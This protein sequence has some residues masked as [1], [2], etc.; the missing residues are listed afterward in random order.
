MLH[1]RTLRHSLTVFILASALACASSSIPATPPAAIARPMALAAAPDRYFTSGDARLRY[2]DIGQGDAVILIHGLSR[3]LDD[4]NG[5]GDSLALDHRVIALDVRGFGKSTRFTDRA[6]LGRQMAEDVVRLMDNL[7]IRR[8]HLAGHSMGAAIAAKIAT[9]YP[10]RVSSV[11]LLAGPFYEDTL[12]FGNDQRG[13]ATEIEQRRSM[14]TLIRWLFPTA[15]DSIVVALN[16]DAMSHNDPATI[17]AAM[18]SMDALLVLPRSAGAI[19]A[20]TV[21]IVGGGDPL[22]P[23]SRWLASWWP[24]ARLVEIPEADH[25]TVL[26]HPRTL[27]AMR[28]IERAQALSGSDRSR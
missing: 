19:R 15:P 13:F 4:W 16:A 24:G 1:L 21:V 22:L 3:S 12:T 9:V 11:A 20:P 8:A 28:S 14:K 18:R 5:V 6:R 25:G 7:G 10:D 26:S 27:Q 23:Q 2:R 17:A